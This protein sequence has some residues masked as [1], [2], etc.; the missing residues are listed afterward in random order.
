[1]FSHLGRRGFGAR[2]ADHE[3]L[4][5]V[6]QRAGLAVLW[7]DNQAGCKGVCA[8]I[9]HVDVSQSRHPVHCRDGTDCLDGIL[10]EGL[11]E[12]IAALAP[13]RRARGVLVVLHTMGSHGPAYAQRSPPQAKR[14]LPECT[15]INLHDCSPQDLR[16]AYD[17]SIVYT[18]QVLGDAIDWLK[19]RQDR[20]E[21]AM[22][23]LS[24]HGESLGENNLYLH[25][26]PY[27][28]APDVQKRVP[29]VSWM[30]QGF[31]EARALRIGCL[32]AV[33]SQPVSHDDLFSSVLWLMQVQTGAYQPERNPYA[34]CAGE[35]RF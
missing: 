28:F 16:N 35:H 23:Y 20:F 2:N 29:W 13:D 7:I 24:D 6:L 10:L 3:N 32:R 17:N 11:E 31:L 30:S 18:D 25:G 19:D 14:F 26:L 8:R 34:P 15:S 27:A 21:T 9:P 5:D 33:A 4:L 1:M 12:R 22:L